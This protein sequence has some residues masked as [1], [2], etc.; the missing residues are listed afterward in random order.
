MNIIINADDF[1]LNPS[2]NRAIVDSLVSGYCSS[3]TIMP[4]MAGFDDACE[5]VRKNQLEKRVGLH[6]VLSHGAPLTAAIKRFPRFCDSDGNFNY[7][8]NKNPFYLASAEKRVLADEILAQIT[9]CRDQGIPITHLDSHYHVHNEWGIMSV[10]IP[11]LKQAG[12]PFVRLTRNFGKNLSLGKRVYKSI[13]NRYLRIRG[14]AGTDHFGGV[15][16]YVDM[17]KRLVFQRKTGSIEI[18]VHPGYD[19]EGRLIDL[20][21]K[22]PLKECICDLQM[23][24]APLSYHAL[25]ELNGHRKTI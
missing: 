12:I 8:R 15:V 11:I 2:I 21:D 7:S 22:R 5:W 13:F 25:L 6:L 18:M 1:G 14:L 24:E 16:D 4:N 3:T 17:K 19:R 20:L 10:L 23:T 9:R